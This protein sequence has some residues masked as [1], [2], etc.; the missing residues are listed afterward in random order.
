M[1]GDDREGGRTPGSDEKPTLLAPDLDPSAPVDDEASTRLHPDAAGGA[2]AAGEAAGLRPPTMVDNFQVQRLLGAGGMGE[3]YLARDM[4]LGR[5]VALKVLH[6]RALGSEDAVERFLFEARTTARFSHPHIVTIYAVGQH[7]THPYVALEYL[8]GET[9]RERMAEEEL[10]VKEAARIGM[11]VADALA[12]AHR[13]RILH[14]DLKPENVM[15]PRD[16]RVRVLDLGLAKV[17]DDSPGSSVDPASVNPESLDDTPAPV[18]RQ[19]RAGG[20]PSYMAPEQWSGGAVSPATDVWALGVTLYE[21]LS[22]RRPYELPDIRALCFQVT[23]DAPVPAME[24]RSPVPEDLI[25]L[26]DRCLDKNP[27]KRPTAREVHGVLHDLLYP[28]PQARE[29]ETSP[30]R[31]LLPFHER[32]SHRFFGRDA[33]VAAFLERLRETPVL[34]VIGPSGAGKSSFVRAGVIPRLR[35]QG[36]W[37]VVTLR[38]GRDP[39]RGLASRLSA[40]V[41]VATADDT[42]LGTSWDASQPSMPDVRPALP[43]IE[44]GV[45]LEGVLRETPGRLGVL[46][47]ELAEAEKARVLLFIDQAEEL[48]TLTRDEGTAHAFLTAIAAAADD[49]EAPIRA[50]LALRDDFMVRMAESPVARELTGRITVLRSP[51]QAQLQEI[52]SRP[53]LDAGYRFEDEELPAEM[54][55]D[56]QG[57]PACLPLLQFACAQLWERRDRQRR[58]I[59]RAAYETIGG[60]SGALATHADG[61]LESLDRHQV[62]HARSLLLRLVTPERTRRTSTRGQLLD[63]L[64]SGATAILD[65]L[66]ADRLLLTRRSRSGEDD[67]EVELAHESL[68]RD[69]SQLSRWIDEGRDELTFLDEV[70]RAAALWQAR[71]CQ[72]SEVWEGDALHDA[73]RRAEPIRELPGPVRRFLDAGGRREEA[74][75]RRTRRWVA[76]TIAALATVA[77]AL[78]V[79]YHEA[80][81][82]RGRAEQERETAVDSQARLLVDGADAALQRGDPLEAR[83]RLRSSLEIRSSTHARALWQRL[84]REPLQWRSPLRSRSGD[85]QVVWSEDGGRIAVGTAVEQ[86]FLIDPRTGDV[87][88]VDPDPGED[89][90]AMCVAFSADGTTLAVGHRSG[91]VSLCAQGH[92]DTVARWKAGNEPL[93]ALAMSPDGRTLAALDTEG[94]LHLGDPGQPAASRTLVPGIRGPSVAADVLAFSPDGEVLAAGGS[95]GVIRLWDLD[96]DAPPRE[97]RA[98][99]KTIETLAFSPDGSQIASGSWD[100]TVRTWDRGTG[101]PLAQVRCQRD[102]IRGIALG[103]R[104]GWIASCSSDRR[105]V[106]LWDVDRGEHLAELGHDLYNADGMAFSPDGRAIVVA[107]WNGIRRWSTTT[108]AARREDRGHHKD[109][110]DLVFSGDGERLVSAGE[111]GDIWV[112]DVATG[113]A[114]STM[115]GPQRSIYSLDISPDGRR[116]ASGGTDRVVCVW[117]LATARLIHVLEGHTANVWGV[118]FGPDGRLLAT[119]AMDMNVRLW[120]SLAGTSIAAMAGPAKG[121]LSVAVRPDGRQVAAGSAD[122]TAWLYS[123]RDASLEHRLEGHG[124][125]IWSVAYSHDGD[126]LVTGGWDQTLRL[127]DPRTGRQ[128]SVFTPTSCELS[129]VGAPNFP[130]VAIDTERGQLTAVC[131]RRKAAVWDLDSGEEIAS[132]AGRWGLDYSLAVSADG[133]RVATVDG[134]MVRLWDAGGR[135]VWRGT[136]M[137]PDLAFHTHDGWLDLAGDGADPPESAW[138]TAVEERASAGAASGD[139]LCL[140]THDGGLELWDR[141]GD[142]LLRQAVVDR[143]SMVY[144]TA[145]GC[146]LEKGGGIVLYLPGDAEPVPIPGYTV[147]FVDEE[148]GEFHVIGD[149]EVVRHGPD[150]RR[151]GAV[152]APGN[153]QISARIGETIAV[154]DPAEGVELWSMDGAQLQ[155]SLRLQD[156]PDPTPI[157][158]LA[159]PGGT[160]VLGFV[161]GTVGIWD[162]H[163]GAL[164]DRFK[165][166]GAVSHLRLRGDILAAATDV[167]D[168]AALDLGALERE[169]CDLLREVWDQVPVAWLDGSPSPA[170]PPAVHPCAPIR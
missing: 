91:W 130:A 107:D 25:A 167:G 19:G 62:A 92:A 1:T 23:S 72:A 111:D 67:A 58:R 81:R 112:W 152:P 34:P 21:M 29:G 57:E 170:P 26:V 24:P 140:I 9:L 94:R 56:V 4:L 161:D 97:I 121:I 122:G 104:D 79:L 28:S 87:A 3:V 14:R 143:S 156:A 142:S 12:E 31:G 129:P 74:R 89:D 73:L 5:K 55:A 133:S 2:G 46:L 40:G 150:G 168:H 42:W 54:V 137:L 149:D 128:R 65:R 157:Q 163:T 38:P 123:V 47:R 44:E 113:A 39:F 118:A 162:G 98:H 120:D 108:A 115:S 151:I 16:G 59:P 117:D 90:D 63:G 131:E 93:A 116:L 132:F 96:A 99:E 136:V 166:H 7:G 45:E 110:R 64:G 139:R 169:Y 164:L 153:A 61:I 20:T 158:A 102:R 35:E 80:R 22:G 127:W 43:G 135:P 84:S 165:L 82:Q 125:D 134:P 17:V 148:R 105:S 13:H 119:G 10:G 48:F 86:Y 106:S 6:P 103:Y 124:H 37:I 88:P 32:H 138:R 144:A 154:I 49:P 76:G 155:R 36:P 126:T 159:G 8:T 33:E 68:I 69:W 146:V 30:F 51:G 70:G 85:S 145:G 71:G 75:T 52:V 41:T 77:L 50:V 141:T 160:L 53:L 95:D 60:V 11:A 27:E 114:T 66:I 100:L 83:A 18:T 109:V 15:I 147:A 101:E 78:G